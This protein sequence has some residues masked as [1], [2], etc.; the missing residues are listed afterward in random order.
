MKVSYNILKKFVTPPREIS[1]KDLAEILTMSTVEV[2]EVVAQLEQLNKVVVGQVREINPHP[3]A[4]KL[5]LAKVDTGKEVCEVVCGGVNLRVG[6][7]VAFAKVGARV[8]WHGEGDWVTLEKAKIRGVESHGMACAA[9][10][11]GIED[12]HALEHGIMDLSHLTAVPGTPL[13]QALGQTDIILE[14]DNKSIT[15]RPD[16]WGH[17]GLARELAAIWRVKCHEPKA[18]PIKPGKDI[19]LKVKVEAKDK[20]VRYM[21][22]AVEGIKV[23]PSPE[24]LVKALN[25]LGARSINNIV[26]I[27]NYV[28]FELGQPLHAFD[29]DKL[30]TPEI[31]V[32]AAKPGETIT[33]LDGIARKLNKNNLLIA[34]I[35]KPIALA[36]IMG[37]EFSGVSDSTTRMVFESATFDPINIRQSE[38]ALVLRTEASI[39]FEKSLDPN[40]AELALRRAVQLLSEVCPSVKVASRVVD[41]YVKPLK[42]AAI[43]LPLAWLN[44]RVGTEFK[45]SEVKDI[46]QRLGFKVAG[47]AK[48]FK[49]TPPTWRATRDITIPEDLIEEVARIHGYGNIPL[50]LPK[51]AINPPERDRAQELRWKI[52]DLLALYGWTETLSYSFVE[53]TGIESVDKQALELVNPVGK[54]EPYLRPFL[55]NTFF[56]QVIENTRRY[57]EKEIKMYEIG[58]TFSNKK[59][60]WSADSSGATKLPTQEYHLVLGCRGKNK[61]EMFRELKV[62]VKSVF[63]LIGIGNETDWREGKA[64]IEV[65]YGNFKIGLLQF[66]EEIGKPSVV[67]YAE[68][69]IDKEELRKEIVM[70]THESPPLYPAIDRDLTVTISNYPSGHVNWKNIQEAVSQIDKLIESV[71]YVGYFTPKQAL[72]LRLTFRSSERTLKSEEVEVIVNEVV[73]QL[74]SKFDAVINS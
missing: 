48:T 8:K 55:F 54:N 37:D 73:K 41:V 4:D 11:L 5:R 40:L 22:V 59:G 13:A 29:L 19:D 9:E 47:T 65:Y 25:S 50:S 62:T 3:N 21:A 36:G 61:L 51:F 66:N 49:V 44:R 15:H 70:P 18:P 10:E 23:G 42:P 17:L 58:R 33:T 24:W 7:K 39:R 52:R 1:A 69:F 14:I 56:Y 35:K 64:G 53:K 38:T 20:V 67:S 30:A 74:I 31:I 46:L 57:P 27:T 12:S 60:T 68:L 72:T 45:S 34:D 16:L 2:E 43:E 26:D 71:D 63:D 28:L 6:M 32:R